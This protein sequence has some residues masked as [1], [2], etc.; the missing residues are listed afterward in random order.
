L[1]ELCRVCRT[2]PGPVCTDD[3]QSIDRQ[4]AELPRRFAAVA[5]ALKPGSAATGERVSVSSD[6]NAPLPARL[7][8]LS[9]IGP[10]SD[11]PAALHPLVRH[12]A[13][14]RT[15]LVTTLVAG[16]AR[17]VKVKVTDWSHE[18]VR[19]V[20]GRP[21]MVPDDQVGTVPPREWLDMQVRRWRAHFGH[22]VPAR[23]LLPPQRPYIPAAYLTLLR[24]TGGA[25]T[26][27]FLAAVHTGRGAHSRMAYRG[28]LAGNQDPATRELE[29]RGG[30][31]AV[32]HAVQWDV[33]YLRAW[34]GQACD[35]GS[36]DIAT[37]A[38]QLRTLH[39]EIGAVLG[40]APDQEWI[41]RC[42]AFIDDLDPDGDP[43]GRKRPCGAGL[44]EDSTAFS[45]QVQCPRCRS[46]WD[47]HGHAG[48]G[49]AREI[50]RV[51]PIDRRRRYTADQIDRL[52]VPKCPACGG[53]VRIEWRDVTGTRDPERTWQPAAASCP[54][55]CDDARRTV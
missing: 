22:H 32:P 7:D 5:G 16:H 47:T 50:R 55:G 25:R 51:W 21:V 9:L 43:T 23:T 34:L 40:D 8:A 10:G 14:R 38:A 24:I 19:G 46:T 18:L 49:T 2:R 30:P 35:Q 45:A 4:L 13:T 1:A 29:R 11:V 52:N 48:A 42:P 12:W 15:V 37:F 33:D 36:L 20:D 31:S 27:A 28:L 17:Q 54:T 3:Q 6:V 41:G 53:R 26:V 44:W 39:A